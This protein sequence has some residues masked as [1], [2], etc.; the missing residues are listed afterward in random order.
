MIRRL[1]FIVASVVG[2]VLLVVPLAAS[3][4]GAARAGDKVVRQA[5]PFMTAAGL[6]TM[7]GD[8]TRLE[9][10]GAALRDVAPPQ[11]AVV[12]PAL[13]RLP[14]INHQAELVVGNLERRR[15]QF[16][17]LASLPG[18]GLTLTQGVWIGL[19]V[20]AALLLAGL[21]GIARQ[22]T[23]LAVA[24]TV[25]GVGLI[26]GPIA[27]DYPS[28]AADA[29]AL[30]SSLRPFSVQKVRARE[31]GLATAR[32]LFARFENRLPPASLNATSAAFARFAALVQFSARAQPLEV[33]ADRLPATALTW[34]L[35]L[36]GVALTLA[37]A[38][39]LGVSRARPRPAGA[40]SRATPLPLA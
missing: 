40:S 4:L 7:R 20:G 34:L 19:A 21:V 9:A 29:D 39:F 14:L 30:V 35:I 12:G 38:V 26:I 18:L 11:L 16:E 6:R 3:Q 8:L 5:S 15:G 27:V 25:A 32:E 36:P 31:A 37:G 2:L 17:S 33:K 24:V 1:P 23:W 22:R 10:A 13:A 28:K